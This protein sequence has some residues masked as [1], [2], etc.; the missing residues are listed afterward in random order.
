MGEVRETP[1]ISVQALQRMP[2]YLN[3]LKE[4]QNS[5]SAAVTATAIANVF[6][7]N[8]IQVRKDLAAICTTKGRP[9]SGFIVNELIENM[10][11]YLG[12]KN[13]MNAVI[14]GAGSLG[15]ALMSYSGFNNY[16]LN[17]AA[18]FD[19]DN[20]IIGDVINGKSVYPLEKLESMCAKMQV[21]IGIIT[22]PAESAQSVCNKL[23]ENGMEAIWNFAPV[24]L[25]VPDS[26]LVQD[27]SLAASLAMLSHHLRLRHP[28]QLN[29]VEGTA[30]RI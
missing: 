22:V 3:Y 25:S 9:R 16:S 7:L 19:T 17:I 6:H 18:A 15:K 26:V 11:N 2:Y 21:H 27:V 5:G 12:Y 24:R 14:I 28:E 29:N 20:D 30:A 13:T 8:E 10:E 1:A 23:V 4:I